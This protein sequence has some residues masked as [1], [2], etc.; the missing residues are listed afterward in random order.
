MSEIWKDI[1]GY[2]GK[3]QVS[4]FGRVRSLKDRWG[5][6]REK[7]L[8]PQ[9]NNGKNRYLKVNICKDSIVK[10]VLVHRLVAE[11][12]IPNPAGYPII[13]HKDENPGNNMVENLEWCD[14]SY[15]LKYGTALTRMKEKLVGR[16][17]WNKGKKLDYKDKLVKEHKM[18]V[19]HW[20]YVDGKRVWY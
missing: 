18:S 1:K 13:N 8:K 4:S 2:E 14:K 16:E 10:P 9:E 17:P 19:R 6:Y 15:N 5:N 3:Y 11:T 20:K 7:L 12:F